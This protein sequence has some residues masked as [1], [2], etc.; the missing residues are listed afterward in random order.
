MSN[1]VA[2]QKE[3]K[4]CKACHSLSLTVLN[5]NISTVAPLLLLIFYKKVAKPCL[6]LYARLYEQIASAEN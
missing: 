2:F 4:L 6:P 3:Y 5:P 1:K